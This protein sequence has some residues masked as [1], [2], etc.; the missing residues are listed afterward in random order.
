MP[1]VGVAGPS[2]LL[3]GLL[4]L[5]VSRP[6][7]SYTLSFRS[8]D[9]SL[10]TPRLE[11]ELWQPQNRYCRHTNSWIR[12]STPHN[13]DE[14][15]QTSPSIDSFT[16]VLDLLG[17]ESDSTTLRPSMAQEL[18]RNLSLSYFSSANDTAAC[19]DSQWTHGLCV[20]PYTEYGVDDYAIGL[21]S[22]SEDTTSRR[23][24]RSRKKGRNLVERA[25]AQLPHIVDFVPPTSTRLGKRI[26]Q[27]STS[28]AKDLLV[29][30]CCPKGTKDLHILDLTAGWGQDSLLLALQSI[31]STTPTGTTRVRR[32]TMVERNPV[33]A[34]LLQD[35]VRRL[36]VLVNSGSEE[37]QERARALQHCLSLQVGEGTTVLQNFQETDLPDVIYLDPMFP[38]RTKQA[39]VKKNMQLLHSLLS[40]QEQSEQSQANTQEEA[41][42][43]ELA[44]TMAPRVV[45]KRPM[46]APPLGNSTPSFQIKGSINRWDVY[47]IKKT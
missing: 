23:R 45:V 4:L 5:F 14:T 9:G 28:P 3:V 21:V 46:T 31:P 18:A 24:Q 42:L 19:D 1:D 34:A 22:V 26:T 11:V 36:Q 30:A 16:C 25:Q 6:A 39:A 10:R 35:A 17:S 32:V 15:T 29:Q 27:Q 47:Q 44:C 41:L 38:P 20:V 7:Q 8:L 37:I 13:D 33:V 2:S 43:L 12:K 40:S